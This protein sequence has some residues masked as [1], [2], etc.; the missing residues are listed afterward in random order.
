MQA[1]DVLFGKFC[2]GFNQQQVPLRFL[3]VSWFT[4]DTDVLQLQGCHSGCFFSLM[5][6]CCDLKVFL[7]GHPLADAQAPHASP[8]GW[9]V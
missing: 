5:S 4:V 9:F 6:L 2:V 3:L 7:P 1:A 8:C